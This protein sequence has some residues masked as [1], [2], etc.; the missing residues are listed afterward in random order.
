[1]RLVIV[2]VCLQACAASFLG[3][4]VAMKLLREDL[5]QDDCDA[6]EDFFEHEAQAYMAAQPLQGVC[7]PRFVAYGSL[8]DDVGAILSTYSIYQL[9]ARP[10]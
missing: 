9:H 10:A 8:V 1:M 7:L 6:H 4:P 5:L 3:V 2:V